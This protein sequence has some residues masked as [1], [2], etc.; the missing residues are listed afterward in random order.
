[1]ECF[2]IFSNVLI[3]TKY[4]VSLLTDFYKSSD[5]YIK[6]ALFGV[7][8][9]CSI[10]LAL[11]FSGVK[12]AYSV[13]YNGRE[14][15]VVTEKAVFGDAVKIVEQKVSAEDV[16]SVIKTP[17]FALTLSA[18][19]PC[20]SVNLAQNI[21]DN[22]EDIVSGVKATVGNETRIFKT[23]DKTDVVEDYLSKYSVGA[24]SCKSSFLGDVSF[25]NG[26]YLL[27]DVEN[28]IPLDSFLSS[29]K[30]L[31][32]ANIK[33]VKEIPYDTVMLRTNELVIGQKK[34]KTEG[35]NG[36]KQI[37]TKV[38][39][40]N[41]KKIK[42]ETVSKEVLTSPMKRV[43]LVGTAEN[44]KIAKKTIAA[45][46]SGF[47]FPIDGS[48]R[49]GDC[50]GA[51]RNHKGY[52]ILTSRGTPIHAVKDGTVIRSSWYGGYG[53]C[54][55]IKH[56]NGLVTRYG[57]ASVLCAKVGQKVQKGDIIAKVG[58]TGDSSGN[59]VHFEV[60]VGGRRVDPAPYLNIN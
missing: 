14:I 8:S 54:V 40:L 32:V 5:R 36:T 60:I 53:Y 46:K 15:A 28:R 4:L 21:I 12:I 30:V 47:T 50:F 42:S 31:T 49:L 52:D 58:S 7:V 6:T 9:V 39:F 20:N 35:A 41:G 19:K 24:I 59:H 43:V 57:H 38:R 33:T 37:I 25:E 26:Y 10:I 55:D 48:Y 23:E 11:V 13:N 3:K 16:G 56:S 18:S 51:A 34:V 44:K 17:D 29:A 27:S 45:R 2:F 22:T 1:M